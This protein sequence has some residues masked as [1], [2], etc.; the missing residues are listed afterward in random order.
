M[1][2]WQSDATPFSSFSRITSLLMSQIH[3]QKIV[4]FKRIHWGKTRLCNNNHTLLQI[5]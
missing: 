3:D 2:R 4:G 5:L 1:L